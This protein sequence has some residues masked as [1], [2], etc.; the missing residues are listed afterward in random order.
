MSKGF[1]ILPKCPSL[2]PTFLLTATPGVTGD[3]SGEERE[4]VWLMNLDSEPPFPMDVTSRNLNTSL[5][6]RMNPG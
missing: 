5:A 2:W 6:F 4:G 3:S 1:P